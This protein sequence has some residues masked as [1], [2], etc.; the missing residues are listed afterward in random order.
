MRMISEQPE[1]SPGT[2]IVAAL[3]ATGVPATIKGKVQRAI[4]RF[5]AGGI[6]YEAWQ[7]IRG[8]LDTIEGRSRVNMMLAEHVGRQAIADPEIVERAKARF[9]GDITRKQENIEAVALLASAAT[10]AAPDSEEVA[11]AREPEPSQ[12]WMNAFIREAENAS[13][14]DLRQRLA[15]VLAGEARKPGTFSRSTVRF[16]A[17][18]DQETLEAFQMALTWRF[19]DA[20][21]IEESWKSGEWF[22][23][24][25]ILEN[26]G[27]VSGVTGTTHKIMKL[28]ENGSGILPAGKIGVVLE[29]QAGSDIR[30][31]CWLVTKLGMEVVSLLPPND[32][33]VAATHLAR[34]VP[35]AGLKS[36][37]VG[38]L[39][40]NPKGELHGAR[41]FLVAWDKDA[42]EGKPA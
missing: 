23:R 38:L 20:I 41:Q 27:L 35:K 33:I 14:S 22:A 1:S 25:T 42:D 3:D 26:V 13:S 6:G 37:W 24:G 5:I 16:I 30:V 9:L 31:N 10:E 39:V 7:E 29:G 15:G 36:I 40:W 28:N 8:N 18:V 34:V 12:D 11:D 19:A 4:L 2:D 17:E 21:I 32:E